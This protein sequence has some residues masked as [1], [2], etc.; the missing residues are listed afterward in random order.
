M[1]ALSYEGCHEV[2]RAYQRGDHPRFLVGIVMS[3]RSAW[4]CCVL[5]LVGCASSKGR[6]LGEVPSASAGPGRDSDGWTALAKER[7]HEAIAKSGG[8]RVAAETAAAA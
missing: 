3:L 8:E 2:D 1:G 4:P 5:V 7:D 6:G